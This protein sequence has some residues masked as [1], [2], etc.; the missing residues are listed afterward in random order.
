MGTVVSPKYP[1]LQRHAANVDERA[2]L[3]ALLGH[4]L[5]TPFKHH[6]PV[7]QAVHTPPLFPE[8]PGLHMQLV[9]TLDPS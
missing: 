1:A 6:T 9:A 2:V 5:D 7:P 4:V 8:Y 3:L